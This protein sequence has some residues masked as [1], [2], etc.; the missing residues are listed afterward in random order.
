MACIWEVAQAGM[1]KTLILF[2]S[3][4]MEE[5]FLQHMNTTKVLAF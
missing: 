2:C 5:L 1:H 3:L 4:C